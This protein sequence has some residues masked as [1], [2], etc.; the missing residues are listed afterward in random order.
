ML[1]YGVSDSLFSA[2]YNV[3]ELSKAINIFVATGFD[4]KGV[5]EHGVSASSFL[6][7]FNAVNFYVACT[8]H[9][10]GGMLKYVVSGCSSSL[11]KFQRHECVW[12]DHIL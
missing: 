5:L 8:F 10:G 9:R 12:S 2:S 7:S 4:G 11:S 1:E 3:S 6:A